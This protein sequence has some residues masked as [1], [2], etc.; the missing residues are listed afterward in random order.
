MQLASEK[1]PIGKSFSILWDFVQKDSGQIST[2]IN[3]NPTEFESF[4]RD[5][6]KSTPQ[7]VLVWGGEGKHDDISRFRQEKKAPPRA[8]PQKTMEPCLGKTNQL[9]YIERKVR[10]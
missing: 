4:L 10:I 8:P 3:L 5:V 9:F 7:A 2:Y 6:S 1:P